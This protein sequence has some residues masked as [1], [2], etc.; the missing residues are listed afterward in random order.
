MSPA[1]TFGV[2]RLLGRFG[3]WLQIGA[4]GV[5]VL[6]GIAMITGQLSAFSCWLLDTFPVFAR[7]G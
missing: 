5:M 7:I 6:T 4:G 3:R 2:E 1:L